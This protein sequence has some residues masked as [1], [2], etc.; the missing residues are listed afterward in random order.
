MTVLPRCF[1]P[2]CEILRPLRFA[3]GG[4]LRGGFDAAGDARG[5]RGDRDDHVSSGLPAPKLEGNP[6]GGG[7]EGLGHDEIQA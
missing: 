2:L 7:G 5:D 3:G 6:H 4:P 1:V